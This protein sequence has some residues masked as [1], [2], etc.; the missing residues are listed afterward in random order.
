M[1]KLPAVKT[2]IRQ[3]AQKLKEH[4]L[5]KAAPLVDEYV[6]AALGE[7]QIQST[8]ADARKEVWSLVKELI[9]KS[10]DRLDLEI[11][12]AQDVLDA[13]SSGKCTMEEGQELLSM[14]KK[15]KEIETAG[16]LPGAKGG[17]AGLQINILTN[18][19][20]APEPQIIEVVDN[21]NIQD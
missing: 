6:A 15:M 21:E 10:S 20:Q 12:S 8:N 19:T 5:E 9:L 7:G 3:T 14:F 1:A 18:P 11:K 17:S 4:F 13:V 16:I 2:D